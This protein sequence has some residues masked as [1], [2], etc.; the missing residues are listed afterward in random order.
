MKNIKRKE[1]STKK[2]GVKKAKREEKRNMEHIRQTEMNKK[3]LYLKQT[4]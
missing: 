2:V 3:L 4:M 1:G